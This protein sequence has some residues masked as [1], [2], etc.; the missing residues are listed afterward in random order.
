MWTRKYNPNRVFDSLVFLLI[1]C[2]VKYEGYVGLVRAALTIDPKVIDLNP[3]SKSM[4]V[5]IRKMCVRE[6][7]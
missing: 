2:K 1:I 3:G 5:S 7:H 6:F 4:D